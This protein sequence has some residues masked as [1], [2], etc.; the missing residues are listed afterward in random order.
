[1]RF[2]IATML[3]MH[4]TGAGAA[5]TCQNTGSFDA[6]LAAFRKDAAAQGISPATISA[7]LGG[8][9]L[10]P[11]I[12][13]RDRKQ[14]FFSQTFLE[15]VEKLATN[16]RLQSGREAIQRHRAAF[17]KAR[18]KYGIPAA[19]IAAF[20]ALESDFGSGMG[21]LPVLRSLATLAYDCRR[22]D[23][24]RAELLD[25]LRIIDRGDLKPAEMIGSWAGELGQTQF[26]PSHYF[27]HAVDFDGD[28]RRDLL[29]SAP[30]IIA[31]TSAYLQYLGWRPDEP[32][33]QEVRVPAS[34]PWD[35]ADIAIQHPRSQWAA[36]G[37]TLP[38]GGPIPKDDM[39]ASLHLPMG[40]HG[41][42][43]LAY[44]NFQVYL[45]WNQALNYATTAAYL[46]TRIDG[47]PPLSKGAGSVVP[48]G[49]ELT[50]DLQKLLANAGLYKGEV[51]GKLGA[52]TRASVK[53]AQLKLGLPADS[54]PTPE[55]VERLRR[56]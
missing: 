46:A 54:Y 6:W 55:L 16:N 27:K 45:K 43:F 4:A 18:E 12:I 7:A 22:S 52:G 21:N 25:A 35:Q 24:F 44:S 3:W 8:M 36:W 49:F 50:R 34:L 40:R 26:L 23:M 33:L 47:A 10:D 2:V 19:V 15:V 1:M 51:D 30:D 37:V 32:W 20:W 53:A 39:P 28:G 11:G 5:V 48:F 29:R 14:S 41:P 42:A 17:Q 31:S 38:N 9:T 56:H 13:S